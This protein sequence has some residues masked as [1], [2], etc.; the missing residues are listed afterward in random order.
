MTSSPE[1]LTADQQ[2]ATLDQTQ[3]APE[4]HELALRHAPLIRFDAGEPFFP[5]VAGY[6]IFRESGPS[7]SFPQLITLERDVTTVI[8]YAIWWDWDIGHLYELEHVWVYLDKDE[9]L[10]GAYASWHGDLHEMLDDT[11]RLPTEQGRALVYSEPGKHAFAAA[12]SW[13]DKREDSTRRSCGKHAGKGGVHVTP[14]FKGIIT[15]RTPQNNRLVHTYLAR[16]SFIPAYDFTTLFALE[17]V[18]LVPWQNLFEWIPRR[19][20]WWTE[21]LKR[22][23]PPA[24]QRVIRIAHRGASAHAQEN[25]LDSIRKAAELGS[26][27]VEVDVQ[28]TRD[29]EPVISHDETLARVYG[30]DIAIRSVTLEELQGAIPAGYAPLMTLEEMARECRSLHMGLYLDIKH[31]N[32]IAGKRILDILKEQGMLGG[33]IIGSFRA[34]WLADIKVAEPEANTSVLFS[35]VHVDP[36]L[37][38]RA[39]NC[40]YVH[41]CW[42]RFD[43]PH[44]FLTEMWLSRVREANLGVVCW[45]EERPEEIRALQTLGVDGICSDMPELLFQNL[46]HNE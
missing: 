10:L 11:G 27:M 28:L 14:L 30:K 23:I 5:S 3:V 42:E 18:P 19:V 1:Y 12:P 36:V 25:S 37:L 2:F 22:T 20:A 31:I 45:H 6:T 26:D 41:P 16:N 34:D 43:Q 46:R 17:S 13:Y 9:G 7:P 32:E 39:I 33:S 8:E 29:N 4:D 44:R 38:A 24:E 21:E 40:D 35:S 15:T